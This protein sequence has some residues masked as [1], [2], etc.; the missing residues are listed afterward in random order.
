MAVVDRL[1]TPKSAPAPRRAVF[2]LEYPRPGGDV[3][4]LAAARGG[5]DARVEAAEAEA[6]QTN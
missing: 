2:A 5:A 4:G 6:A 3:G 1:Q